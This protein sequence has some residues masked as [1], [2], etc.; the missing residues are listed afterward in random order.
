MASALKSLRAWARLPS[1]WRHSMRITCGVILVGDD[2]ADSRRLVSASLVWAGFR[3]CE[4]ETG[5]EALAAAQREQP[6]LVIL[7]VGL[8]VVSGYMVCRELRDRYGEGLPIIFL[9]GERT[10]PLDRV[11]GLLVGA[12]DYLVKPFSPDELVA[13][14]RRFVTRARTDAAG[15]GGW[16]AGLTRRE[17]EVL[18]LLA[19]GLSQDRIAQELFISPKTVATHI[20]RILIKL[21][22][23]SRAQAVAFAYQYGLSE[24]Q[25]HPETVF[26]P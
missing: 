13:R 3:V 20:Q 1:D 7:D 4:A 5:N 19:E 18:C 24:V 21:G 11:A 2:D 23:R 25:A 6:A 12:D 26:P 22:V 15:G 14:V 10:D 8:P 9:S 16:A 17:R